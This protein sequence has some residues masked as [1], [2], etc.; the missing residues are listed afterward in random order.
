MEKH[1]QWLFPQPKGEQD[2]E[3]SS[4]PNY[5]ASGS[6]SDFEAMGAEPVFEAIGSESESEAIGAQTTPLP[7]SEKTR[8]WTTALK[9]R[10]KRV[11]EGE[12][13]GKLLGGREGL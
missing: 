9:A 3:M 11:G 2:L 7:T 1:F 6:E 12:W 10:W 4:G 13:L 5:E 8:S